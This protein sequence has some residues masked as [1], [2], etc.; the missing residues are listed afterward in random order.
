M[1]LGN[2][3]KYIIDQ[4]GKKVYGLTTPMK[5]HVEFYKNW[6]YVSDEV[7]WQ[8]DSGYQKPCVMEIHS[9]H[10]RYKDLIIYAKRK[11][12]GIYAVC[13]TGYKHLNTLSAIIGVGCYGYSDDEW[14]GVSQDKIDR[15]EELAEKFNKGLIY[16]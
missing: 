15:V 6:L 5:I 8:E 4:T 12:S 13:Y 11:D 9:G 1:A 3:D 7:A 10:F 2:W 16:F 14:I